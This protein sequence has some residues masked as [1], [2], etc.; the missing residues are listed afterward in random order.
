M[1]TELSTYGYI[2]RL[3]NLEDKL[4]EDPIMTNDI[5]DSK[6]ILIQFFEF[7]Q[8]L[9][10]NTDNNK[11]KISVE[12][13]NNKTLIKYFILINNLGYVITNITLNIYNNSTEIKVSNFKNTYFNDEELKNITQFDFT[14][15]P[16]FDIKHELKTNI[17]YY[18]TESK[19]LDKVLKNGLIS[20]SDNILSDYPERIYC[21]YNLQDAKQY[22]E[23][24]QSYY[25][26]VVNS[27]KTRDQSIYKKLEFVIL[28]IKLLDDNNLIFYEDLDS[29]GKGIYTYDKIEPKY[30][31]L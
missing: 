29:K 19:Y 12:Y 9:K 5:H 20:K 8:L 31:K 23:S 21:V 2:T 11:I 14:L 1:I 16:K 17:L 7:N 30:I 22:I 26:K 6:N 18:V 28:N 3:L 10:I 15:E 4:S 27:Y 24:K 13:F 25:R